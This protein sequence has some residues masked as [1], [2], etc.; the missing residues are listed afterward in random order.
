MTIPLRK[1]TFNLIS[2]TEFSL[3]SPDSLIINTSRSQIVNELALMKYLNEG[4]IAGAALDVTSLEKSEGKSFFGIKINRNTNLLW[5]TKNL[6]IT[7]HIA[8]N[9]NMLTTQIQLDFIRK[10]N[11][12]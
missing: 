1:S 7:P 3:M 8:G 10:L 11:D 9:I 6:L 4:K 5:S 2:E 12:V